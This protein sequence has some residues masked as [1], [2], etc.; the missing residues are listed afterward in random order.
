MIIKF[1]EIA[2][3]RKLLSVR[4]DLAEK[5]TLF[6]GANNSGKSSA[7]LALRRFLVPRSCQFDVHDV[8]L[9]HWPE[10]DRIGQRWIEAKRVDGVADLTLEPWL[11]LPQTSISGLK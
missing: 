10:I 2:N 4:I 8:T 7:M 11:S 1:V 9:C 3:F 5:Q 6:V